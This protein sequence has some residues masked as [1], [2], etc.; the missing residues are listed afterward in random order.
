MSTNVVDG[1]ALSVV[2]SDAEVSIV[3]F[4]EL[5]SNPDKYAGLHGYSDLAETGVVVTLAA[6]VAR[7]IRH[8]YPNAT[9]SKR[10]ALAQSHP[11]KV[12]AAVQEYLNTFHLRFEMD[13]AKT[14]LPFLQSRDDIPVKNREE[15]A[16]FN[17]PEHPKA[18]TVPMYEAF[19]DM[20]AN[21]LF[22]L[23]GISTPAIGD[24]RHGK[25]KSG[26]SKPAVINGKMYGTP[27]SPFATFQVITLKR[28]TLFGTVCANVSLSMVDE[29]SGIPSW[30]H[31]ADDLPD[32]FGMGGT[33]VS[34]VLHY[35]T[36]SY[37]MMRL[38]FT[39]DGRVEYAIS[40]TGVVSP[41]VGSDGS[42][43]LS[44]MFSPYAV[45]VTPP[46]STDSKLINSPPSGG[47]SDLKSFLLEPSAAEQAAS[48]LDR[49]QVIEDLIGLQTDQTMLN[50]IF[51]ETSVRVLSKSTDSNFTTYKDVDAVEASFDLRVLGVPAASHTLVSAMELSREVRTRYM[52]FVDDTS[53]GTAAGEAYGSNRFS[54]A[55]SPKLRK[56]IGSLHVNSNFAAAE[57]EWVATVKNTAKTVVDERVAEIPR[58]AMKMVAGKA[59]LSVA[60]ARAKF[61]S[62]I[63]TLVGGG[64]PATTPT[65]TPETDETDEK[66]N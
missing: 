23:Q 24:P 49:P 21:N 40:T 18:Q 20:V 52:F 61:L 30:E 45:V 12:A 55:I 17:Y 11:A 31:A 42:R 48:T 10:Y 65:T 4:M 66:D 6:L 37:R 14:P 25:P 19:G 16:L 8:K 58:S 57:E 56:F 15:Y 36:A 13:P 26:K 62:S 27:A 54:E 39:D 9:A 1:P 47:L 53:K 22:S 35:L 60:Q 63:N 44:M 5:F 32:A 41:A 33:Q 3:G 50:R 38:S 59:T 64:Q 29:D 34:S 7:A 2:T 28:P 43:E 51:G 46:N